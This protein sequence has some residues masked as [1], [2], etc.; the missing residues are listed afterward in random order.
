MIDFGL[1]ASMLIALGVPSLL[2]RWWPIKNVSGRGTFVDGVFGPLGVGIAVGRI[3]ALALDDPGAL[4][5]LSDLLII[6]S[7]VEF[8]PGLGAALIVLAVGARRAGEQPLE[9][10]AAFGPLSLVAYG[11]FEATCLLRGGCYGPSAR[12][13]LRPAG[14]GTTMLPVGIFMG[15]AMVIGSFTLRL[16][17]RRGAS[18]VVLT[19]GALAVLASVR[20]V[21]SIWLPKVSPGLTRAHRTSLFVSAGAMVALGATIGSQRR[22]RVVAG[23]R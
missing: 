6:R 15:V 21:A 5:R 10:I 1:L 4:G 9:R 22:R 13:G 8:W 19:S 2:A 14:L 16:A 23:E 20:S 18:A 7:G 3:T 12:L 17:G 11:L